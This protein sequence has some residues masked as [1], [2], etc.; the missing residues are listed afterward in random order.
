MKHAFQN[1]QTYLLNARHSFWAVLILTIAVITVYWQVWN[2]DFVRFDDPA[3]VIDTCLKTRNPDNSLLWIFRFHQGDGKYWQPLT[4]LSHIADCRMFGLEPELHHYTNLIFHLINSILLFLFLRL[5]LTDFW[6]SFWIAMLFAIHPMN[7]ESV[8]WISERKNLISSFFFFLSLITYFQYTKKPSRSRYLTLAFVFLLGLLAKPMLVTLPVILFLLDGWPL[9]RIQF[10]NHNHS[11]GEN[12]KP[13]IHDK[14]RLSYLVM[15]KAPLLLLSLTAMCMT[16]YSVQGEANLAPENP[17]SIKLRT[18]NAVISIIAY[19]GKILW[20]FNLS[21]FYPYP[22]TIIFWKPLAAVFLLISFTII[23]FRS[24]RSSPYLISGWFWFLITLLP[25]LGI[26]QAGLW[27]AMADRWAY[28]PAIGIFIIIVF[29]ME[30]IFKAFSLPRGIMF[31]FTFLFTSALMVI[32]WQ[33]VRHWRSSESLYEQVLK[34]T[35]GNFMAHNNMGNILMENGKLDQAVDHFLK[36]IQINPS[37]KEAQINLANT[38]IHQGKIQKALNQYRKLLKKYPGD[39]LLSNNM[40]AAFL[41]SGDLKQA[42]Y[43]FATAIQQKKN[44]AEAYNNLGIA[45]WE[46]YQKDKSMVM[47]QKALSIDPG[48]GKAYDNMIRLT[49]ARKKTNRELQQLLS[50]S[51]R[52]PDDPIHFFQLGQFFQKEKNIH[53]SIRYYQKALKLRPD[54]YEIQKQLSISLAMKGDYETAFSILRGLTS[55]NPGDTEA[56]YYMASIRSR[57]NIAAEAIQWLQKAI[58]HG[59]SDWESI[60]MDANFNNIRSTQMFQT[61]M[62]QHMHDPRPE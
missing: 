32:T 15:E 5:I 37:Y 22:E 60:R 11:V 43:Y 25:V 46:D 34:T 29:S 58:D 16:I 35:S 19:V 33:Q 12:T 27:P 21:F 50:G 55:R 45:L 18:A 61:L 1:N 54:E 4:L 62:T 9:R 41:H 24:Y 56:Y 17:H 59:F 49:S 36:A 38:W 57:Q 13:D 23:C 40:G 39:A 47:F 42:I 6:K 20:P 44:Y 31:L 14:K 53:Q 2:F 48:C 28:L 30:A 8:A 51:R 26:I 7:V 10:P 52:S 3:Y